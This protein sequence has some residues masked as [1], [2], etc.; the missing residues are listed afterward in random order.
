MTE[1]DALSERLR[2]QVKRMLE[3]VW[4]RRAD[5]KDVDDWLGQFDPGEEGGG[6]R[7]Q[8][9]FLLSQFMYFGSFEVRALLKA[10]YRDHFRY[11]I[12][13]GIRRANAD[14]TDL[15]LISSAYHAELAVTRFVGL[16]NPSESSSHLL[17][18]FRQENGLPKDLFVGP[19]DIFHFAAADDGFVQ[20]LR[21]E[22]IRNYV[23]IDDLCGSGRQVEGYS[24]NIAAPLRRAAAKSGFEV[25]IS[26]IALF[27]TSG[28]IA[29]VQDLGQ[30]DGVDCVVELDPSFRC[31]ADTSRYYANERAPI[32]RAAAEAMCRR[33]GARLSPDHP[34]GFEDGQLLLAFSHNTPDN[35]LPIFSSDDPRGTAWKPLFKRYDKVGA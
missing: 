23:L 4:E 29:H 19:A 21:D 28:G 5:L 27:A 30:F 9:F 2:V 7:L 20:V 1:E 12:V 6:E 10:L 16:G 13:A 24:A 33:H 8:A 26:Y 31:F 34:L 17:Y 3:S 18:Y 35:T 32:S 15:A 22:T 25:R 11:P 14:T